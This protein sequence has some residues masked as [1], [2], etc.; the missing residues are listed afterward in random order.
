MPKAML[1]CSNESWLEYLH[2]SLRPICDGLWASADFAGDA[3]R[4]GSCEEAA[5]TGGN[6]GKQMTWH[7]IHSYPH[8]HLI[9]VVH[10]L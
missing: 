1:V 2:K 8:I 4:A 10:A 7:C 9:D 3:G 5:G 6:R